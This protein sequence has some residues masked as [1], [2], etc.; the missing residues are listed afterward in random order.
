MIITSNFP[1]LN[2]YFLNNIYII[3]IN[4]KKE[5]FGI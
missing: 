5:L 3:Y 1:F 2:D 4:F